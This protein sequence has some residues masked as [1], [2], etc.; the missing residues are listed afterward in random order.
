MTKLV[1]RALGTALLVLLWTTVVH[2]QG[3]PDRDLRART[4]FAAG[5]YKEA[6]DAYATL[7]AETLHPTY[8]RNIGRCHQKLGDP[9]RAIDSFREYLRKADDLT[10][11][12]RGEVE[13]F[14]REMEELKRSRSAQPGVAPLS[15]PQAE[16][17]SSGALSAAPSPAPAEPAPVYKRWWFW[18][19]VGVLAAGGTAAVLI[20]GQKQSSGCLGITP[21]AS[22][23]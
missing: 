22:V 10:T 11:K 1:A 9:D 12:Q 3:A 15:L 19:A 23:K 16:P 14:I 13:G 17:P 18:T 8:L 20:A 5:Q 7:Y 4:H 21:C 2:A 6:L